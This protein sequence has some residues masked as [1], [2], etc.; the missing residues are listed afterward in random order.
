MRS[1]LFPPL[2]ICFPI[3]IFYCLED[4]YIQPPY[5]LRARHQRRGYL[6][7]RE[8]PAT[9]EFPNFVSSSS[10]FFSFLIY[11]VIKEKRNRLTQSKIPLIAI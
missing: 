2:V 5:T 1:P 11:N 4:I 7:S 10:S 8:F 6:I 9:I 3:L